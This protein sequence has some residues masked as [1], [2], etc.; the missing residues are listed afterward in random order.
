M[1]YSKIVNIKV[2]NLHPHPDN[3]RKDVGDVSELADSIRKNGLMQNLTVMPIDARELDPE[4]QTDPDRISVL[5][6][7]IVLIGHRRLKAAKQ[8]GLKELPCKIV[9]QISRKEQ[10]GIMMEENMQRNDLTIWEEANGFQMML[11][12]GDTEDQIAEKTGFSKSTIRHRVNI[13]KLDQDVL[14]EKEQDD[15]YQLTLKGLY[16]LEKVTDVEKRNEILRSSSSSVDLVA[17]ARGA[18]LSEK[19][20]REKQKIIEMLTAAGI[21]QMSK[22]DE[23][24]IWYGGNWEKVENYV[25]GT[26]KE[27]YDLPECD[28]KLYWR[29]IWSGIEVYKKLKP[30]KKQET[31]EE[32]REKERKAKKKKIKEIMERMDERRKNL[33]EDIISGKIAPV[34]NEQTLKDAIWMLIVAAGCGVYRSTMSE[35]FLTK[36]SYQCTQAERDEALEKVDSLSVYHQMLVMLSR[37]MRSGVNEVHDW[38]VEYQ[39]KNGELRLEAYRI[40]ELYGWYFEEGEKEILDGTSDLYEGGQDD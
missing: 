28:E 17:R 2:K 23:E 1:K 35:E 36:D 4:K 14:K 26:G 33:L 3:P 7:F 29:S 27:E 39:K 38:K 24:R 31:K 5:S 15:G 18:V 34:K 32:K 21:E 30:Q 11:D 10:I 8:A 19:K 13:A 25:V 12:L 20:E 37:T 40:F 6:D 16:E 22:K 9:S